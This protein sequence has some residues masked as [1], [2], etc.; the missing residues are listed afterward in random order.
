METIS[1]NKAIQILDTKKISFFS[2]NDA[3]KIFQI[4]NN[5]TLYKLLQ[6]LEASDIIKRAARGKYFFSYRKITDFELANFL[7]VPSYISLESALSFYGILSQF[8]Y[9][10]TSITINKSKKIIYEDKEFEFIHLK[11]K[12]FFGFVG[13]AITKTEKN[14]FLIACPEKALIDELYFMSKKIRR[15][16]LIDLDLKKINKN[17]LKK[18]AS[19]YDFL[20]FKKLFEKYVR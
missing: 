20:P 18:M 10:I 14:K 16:S 1:K 9:T 4:R 19:Q 6:R 8:P 11:N 5:N 2:I 13:L 3:R 12:Y 15:V 7:A 17:K